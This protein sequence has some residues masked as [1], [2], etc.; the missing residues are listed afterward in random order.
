MAHQVKQIE[1]GM[2]GVLCIPEVERQNAKQHQDRPGQGVQ[3]KLDG[4]VEF[5]RPAPHADYE[6]HRHQHHFPENVEEEEVE[7]HENAEHAHLQ[8]HEHGVVLF[9]PLL[10]SRPGR[11]HRQEPEH[12]GQHDEQ[13]ADAVNAQV[14]GGADGGDPR[15]AFRKDEQA[16]A[17][18]CRLAGKPK[19]QRQRHQEIR[20]QH[21]VSPPADRVLVLARYEQKR[22]HPRERQE[23]DDAQNVVTNEL[24]RLPQEPVKSQ[25]S[26]VEGIAQSCQP[27]IQ[28]KIENPKSKMNEI[29]CHQQ[30]N[31]QHNQQ[32]VGLHEACLHDAHHP[33]KHFDEEGEEIY[34]TVHDIKVPKA[35]RVGDEPRKPAS[36]IYAAVHH[37]QVE[38]REAVPKVLHS[39]DEQGV[40]K[41]IYVVLIRNDVV[42]RSSGGRGLLGERG[43]FQIHLPRHEYSAE[44]HCQ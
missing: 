19:N 14:V 5:A 24:H 25:Q 20:E 44:G 27:G 39:V 22:N 11:K 41:L 7:G 3:E 31:A 2:A 37:T 4:G 17:G 26:K 38:R 36:A 16:F 13:E 8:K 30:K 6:I 40:V 18:F 10:H 29:V 28:S 34:E 33:T 21:H 43:L 12:R 1:R 23:K 9:G 32:R 42:D 35:R 15:R